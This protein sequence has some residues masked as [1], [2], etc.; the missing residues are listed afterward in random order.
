M[1]HEKRD[2]IKGTVSVKILRV[3]A[4]DISLLGKV[5]VGRARSGVGGGG[6]RQGQR[7]ERVE[8]ATK[9]INGKQSLQTIGRN[10]RLLFGCS[11][12]ALER[13]PLMVETEETPYMHVLRGRPLRICSHVTLNY[14]IGGY[15]Y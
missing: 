2:V 13:S 8:R 10:V 4:F 3:D 11:I 15:E 14:G 1:P 5:V 6:G 7:E 9:R 12:E